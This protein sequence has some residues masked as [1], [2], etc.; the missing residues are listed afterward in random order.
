ML[1]YGALELHKYL[2]QLK[3]CKQMKSLIRIFIPLV[4]LATACLEKADPTLE[5]KSFFR[6]YDNAGFNAAFTPIDMQQTSDEGYLVLASKRLVD[7]NFTGIYLLKV[8]KTGQIVNEVDDFDTQYV[9]PVG[10][11]LLINGAYHFVCMD[12]NLQQ[13][14]LVRLNANGDIDGAITPLGLTYPLAI[15]QDG[16]NILL[17]SYDNENKQMALNQLNAT[18]AIT[19][20]PT[21]FS[22]GVGDE[23]EEPIINHFLQGGRK[24]PFAIGRIPGA[25]LYFNGFYNY[26][27]S[28]VFFSFGADD[29]SGVVYGQ[30]DDGGFSALLPLSASQFAAARFNFGDNFLLPQVNLAANGLTIGTE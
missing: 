5:E 20:T 13:A 22:I 4:F 29:P 27:F 7:N 9:N 11:L 19:A 16:N 12:T 18:G 28:M 6:I 3:N 24:F 2:P 1:K 17:L 8:D 21:G 23:T 10:P 25:G 30:Q 15:N 26:T 14:Q